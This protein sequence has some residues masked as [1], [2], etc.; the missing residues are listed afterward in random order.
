MAVELRNV[1][2]RPETQGSS[3]LSIASGERLIHMAG[4]VG[5]D[6]HGEVVAGGLS[7]QT[8]RA[9]LNVG[10]VL[11]EAG[12]SESDLV[13]L[14]IYVVDWEP[15]MFDELGAGILAARA[16]RPSPDVPIT[17][18][19]VESLF[20]PEMRVEIEGVAVSRAE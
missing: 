1:P 7:A 16:A 5:T 20:T 3:Q 10:R 8:E 2:G 6:E 9:L 4:Q 13:K 17:L 18:L 11:D 19:G 12:A 15:S 14:T